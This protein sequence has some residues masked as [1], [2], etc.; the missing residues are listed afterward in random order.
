MATAERIE[1]GYLGSLLRLTLFAPG[2]VE[3]ILD[4]HAPAEVTLPR[5]LEPFALEWDCQPVLG[6]D[7]SGRGM[8]LNVA[9]P[10]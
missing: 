10:A 6:A 7:E 4:G 5:L 2:I 8:R 3:S 1:R 9:A